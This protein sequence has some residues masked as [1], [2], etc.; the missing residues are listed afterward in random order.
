MH[1]NYYMK[2]AYNIHSIITLT[3][4]C[5]STIKPMQRL[6]YI[7]SRQILV[8]DFTERHSVWRDEMC[9]FSQDD[10]I[11]Q[12]LFHLRAGCNLLT[13]TSLDPA[14]KHNNQSTWSRKSVIF[15]FRKTS[16]SAA[17]FEIS[18]ISVAV[19]KFY[20]TTTITL[21]PFNS[22]F[23]RTT[24]VSRQQKGKPFWILMKQKM[25]GWQWYQLDYIQIICTSLQTDNHAIQSQ[26]QSQI[27]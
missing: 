22:L 5:R 10:A 13:N 2:Q 20:N 23:S 26:I 4:I 16:Y 8:V 11:T 9:Q 3:E 25:M 17:Q 15:Y 6:S 27:Y 14:A 18:F 19:Q 12:C 24:W 1:Y 7:I 21:P